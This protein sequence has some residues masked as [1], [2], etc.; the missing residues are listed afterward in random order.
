MALNLDFS[1]TRYTVIKGADGVESIIPE[2]PYPRREIRV[3]AT[4]ETSNSPLTS[5][6]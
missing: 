5:G 6:T 3:I 4:P 2:M 1:E